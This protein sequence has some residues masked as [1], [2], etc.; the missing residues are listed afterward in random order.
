VKRQRLAPFVAGAVA[1]VLAVFVVL[2]ATADGGEDGPD[3]RLIGRPAPLFVGEGFRGDEFDLDAERGNWVV[4]N[5]FSTTCVPCVIEHPE[6]VEFTE[7]H[8][9]ADDASVVSVTFDDRAEDVR[10][11]F[12]REGGDWPVLLEDT[13]AVAIDYGVVAVP[14]SYLVDPFGVVRSK[15]TGGVTADGIDATIARLEGRGG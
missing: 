12:E 10:A 6:L 8:A 15:W 4:V 11:F 5:F 1:V 9:E 3:S 7:R 2:L 14:E 13:G